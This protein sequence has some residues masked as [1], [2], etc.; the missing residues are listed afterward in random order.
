NANV[1]IVEEMVDM[2]VAQRAYEATS[3]VIKTS[4][5]MMQIANNLR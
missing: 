2:I 5:E 4:D 1:S 3:K